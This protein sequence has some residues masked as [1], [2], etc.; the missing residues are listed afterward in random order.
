MRARSSYTTPRDLT[1]PNV[2]RAPRAAAEWRASGAGRLTGEDY[3]RLRRAVARYERNAAA[4][5]DGFPAG[6]LAG[7][8]HYGRLG[9][10]Q[11]GGPRTLAYA[12]GALD[13]LSRRMRAEHTE[14][15]AGRVQRAM[16]RAHRRRDPG[17]PMSPIAFRLRAR[18]LGFRLQ[19]CV[20]QR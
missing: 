16:R 15:D 8:V 11:P 3:A 2:A 7:L 13:Q 6:G 1:P 20:R 12:I 9:A 4:R 17:P 5:P 18:A 10:A 14:G 19:V